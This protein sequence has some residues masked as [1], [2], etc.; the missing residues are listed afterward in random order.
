MLKKCPYFLVL[1][2]SSPYRAEIL[3]NIAVNFI[4]MAPN[5]PE[6]VLPNES[7]ESTVMRLAYGK[8]LSLD[9]KL[10]QYVIVSSDQVAHQGERIF[11]KPE[12]YASAF[13]QLKQFQGEWVSFTTSLYLLT[14]D[15]KEKAAIETFEVKFRCLSEKEIERYLNIDSPYDCAGSIKVESAGLTLLED[16]R[17]RDINCVYGLPVMLLREELASLKLDLLDFT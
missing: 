1:G 14:H 13:K 6:H 10:K 8:A 15:G 5:F 3:S 17:G 12:N 9:V 7:P 4:Q 16:A 11:N 2:S